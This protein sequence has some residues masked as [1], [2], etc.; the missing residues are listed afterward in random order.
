MG[1]RTGSMRVIVGAG[2][3][4]VAAASH[5]QVS[6]TNHDDFQDG[7]TQNWLNGGMATDPVNVPTGGPAGAGDAYCQSSGTGIPGPGGN[8]SMFNDTQWTG[9]YLA[10]GIVAITAD[11]ANFGPNEVDMRI[12]LHG[13]VTQRYTSTVSQTVP[14]DGVWRTYEFSILEKDL[15]STVTRDGWQVTVEN[16]VRLQ[17]R[18]Q[19]GTPTSG[20]TPVLATVGYDN[21]RAKTADCLGDLDG[22]GSV[23]GSD[24]AILLGAWGPC[25]GCPA[26]LDGSGDVSGSDLALLLGAWGD[27]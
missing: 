25:A 14:P 4:C 19:S 2:A 24:L 9:D 26:D 22:D 16:A 1:I 15:T 3:L 11:I 5:G 13:P 27:C 6:A 12:V 17:F 7:T 10:E 18:N 21:I 23:S 20:G 8:P